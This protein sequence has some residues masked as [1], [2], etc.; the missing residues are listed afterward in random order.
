MYL[1]HFPAQHNLLQILTMDGGQSHRSTPHHSILHNIYPC[2]PSKWLN[3][4]CLESVYNSFLVIFQL[5]R[6][7]PESLIE[8]GTVV[9]VYHVTFV[10]IGLGLLKKFWPMAA[11]YALQGVP[12]L[13]LCRPAYFVVVVVYHATFV[14]IGHGLLNKF[15]PMVISCVLR[16]AG[17]FIIRNYLLYI[18]IFFL[19]DLQYV[20]LLSASFS[21][22][23]RPDQP[24]KD[25]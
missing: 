19:P 23:S 15:W 20:V 9:V 3:V 4:N 6:R 17:S 10:A 7:K 21:S 8:P 18:Y 22:R 16:T 13:K 11:F 1:N 25:K 5:Q 24:T 12:L 2:S 14:A